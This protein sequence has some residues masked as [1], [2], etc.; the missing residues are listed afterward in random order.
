MI[1]LLIQSEWRAK[2]FPEG[3]DVGCEE[4]RIRQESG[5]AP[6]LQ[7]AHLGGE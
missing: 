7:P 2:G 5:I 3:S 4:A 6:T 1:G